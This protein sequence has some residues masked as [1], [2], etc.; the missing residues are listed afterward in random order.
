LITNG[1]DSLEA[2]GTVTVEVSKQQNQAAI[3]VSDNGCGMTQEVLKHLF[4]PFFT[5]RK[6]GQGTGLGLSITYRIVQ[7]HGG[8]IDVASPGPGKGSQFRVTLPLVQQA[9]HNEKRQA[10]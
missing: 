7:E 8:G 6:D 4:E 1:L 9:Q 5:R 3:V 10:A 2:G